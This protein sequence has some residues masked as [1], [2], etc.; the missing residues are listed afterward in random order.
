MTRERPSVTVEPVTANS[1]RIIVGE[2]EFE[3]IA[4][5]FQDGDRLIVHAKGNKVEV[6][7]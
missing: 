7:Q 6:R 5:A 1:V 4:E 3:I 2:C